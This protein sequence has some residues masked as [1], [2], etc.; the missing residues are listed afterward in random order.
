MRFGFSPRFLGGVLAVF[1]SWCEAFMTLYKTDNY[2]CNLRVY[3]I[4]NGRFVGR[5]TNRAS[6]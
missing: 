6:G 5:F 3:S 1:M 4:L 2:V